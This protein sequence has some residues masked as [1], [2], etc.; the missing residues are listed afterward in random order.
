MFNDTIF[1]RGDILITTTIARFGNASY[2]I[3]SIAAVSTKDDHSGSLGCGVILAVGGAI[4]IFS[5]DFRQ[6]LIWLAIGV[7]LIWVGNLAT[8]K[9][10]VL[11]TSSGDQQVFKSRDKQLVSELKLAI[12]TAVSKRG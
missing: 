10:L 7:G 9:V 2:P 12:E 4:A 3:A 11:A 6:G 8:K 1:T 5:S